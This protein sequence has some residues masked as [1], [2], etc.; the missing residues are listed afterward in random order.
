MLEFPKVRGILAEHT[1]FS[2]SRDLALNL[3]P[4]ADVDVVSEALARSAEARRLL[5]LNPDFA[6]RGAIDVREA[7]ALAARGKVLAPRR[8]EGLSRQRGSCLI[9]HRRS[10]RV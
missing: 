7:V 8:S 1:A 4:S 5:A 6:V 10:W 2:G 3:E 9:R